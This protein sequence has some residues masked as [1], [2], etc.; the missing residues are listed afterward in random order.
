[1]QV[2]LKKT[3]LLI[4]LTLV[5]LAGLFGWTMKMV[6]TPVLQP[7]HAAHVSYTH[8]LADG[9]GTTCLPPPFNC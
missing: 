2:S 9:P 5:L 3:V 8:V 4:V 6:L 7:H 1:M